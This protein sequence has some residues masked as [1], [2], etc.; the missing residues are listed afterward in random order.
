MYKLNI[1]SHPVNSGALV[2]LQR[3]GGEISLSTVAVSAA[4]HVSP[5]YAWADEA[6]R[7]YG[8]SDH[9]DYRIAWLSWVSAMLPGSPVYDTCWPSRTEEERALRR[10]IRANYKSIPDNN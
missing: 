6:P 2:Q 9:L 10:H 8:D 5:V 3:V 7:I 4:S 1:F